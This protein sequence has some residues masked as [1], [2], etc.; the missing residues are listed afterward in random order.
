MIFCFINLL[1]KETR[2]VARFFKV[3]YRFYM[4]LLEKILLSLIHNYLI[5]K[6]LKQY[7][8]S[9]KIT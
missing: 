6:I 2:H 8:V 4:F 1:N 9:N 3:Y 7:M 5:T